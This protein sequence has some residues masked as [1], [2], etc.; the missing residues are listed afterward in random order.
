MKQLGTPVTMPA[1]WF[2]KG[3]SSSNAS[4][5]GLMISHGAATQMAF[6]YDFF[7]VDRTVP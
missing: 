2:A 1:A 7:R 4:L 6:V 3:G 5:T